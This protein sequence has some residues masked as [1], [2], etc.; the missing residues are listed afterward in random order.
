MGM[1]DHN[2]AGRLPIQFCASCSFIRGFENQM[3]TLIEQ[4]VLYSKR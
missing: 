2:I 1:N 4:S 3:I